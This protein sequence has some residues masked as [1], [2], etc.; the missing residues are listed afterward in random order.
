MSQYRSGG[1]GLFQGLKG[2]PAIFREIPF[3]FF[4]SESGERNSDIGVVVNEVLI[5]VSKSEERLDVIDF[6]WLQ[7]FLTLSSD[8]VSPSGERMY[9]RYSTELEWNSHLS[10]QV[11]S[12]RCQSRRRTS[13]T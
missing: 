9:L 3:D 12:P 8:I 11:Y 1:K 6:S 7:P 5:E 10:A 13:P 4:P 2:R